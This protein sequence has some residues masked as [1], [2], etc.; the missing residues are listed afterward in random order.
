MRTFSRFALTMAL[1]FGV[2]SFADAATILDVDGSTGLRHNRAFAASWTQTSLF[3]EVTIT[4]EVEHLA[5]AVTA[6]A[7]LTTAIGAGT[8]VADQ[9]ATAP[10]TSST[11]FS[12]L[13]LD[14]GTYYLVLMLEGSVGLGFDLNP[15]VATGAGVSIGSSYDGPFLTFPP[16]GPSADF[17]AVE[18]QVLYSV[19]GTDASVP[20][21]ATLLLLGPAEIL[22][23]RAA[24]RRHP[25]RS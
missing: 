24:R 13:T 12:G 15:T 21:P 20:E 18:G 23:V 8:T 11:I 17:T 3:E 2:A 4:A 6:T 16:F 10:I 9:I 5:S 22:V 14:A 19:S 1:A 25:R 7:W